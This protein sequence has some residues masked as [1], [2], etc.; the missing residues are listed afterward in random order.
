MSA[1]V[2]SIEYCTTRQERTMSIR[3]RSM[4]APSAV[5]PSFISAHP[6]RRWQDTHAFAGTRAEAVTGAVARAERGP[7]A[8][9]ARGGGACELGGKRVCFAPREINRTRTCEEG[10]VLGDG[11]AATTRQRTGLQPMQYTPIGTMCVQP[12]RRIAMK[13]APLPRRGRAPRTSA[14]HVQRAP[15]NAV[16]E[17]RPNTRPLMSECRVLSGTAGYCRV[18]PMARTYRCRYGEGVPA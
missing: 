9:G 18:R 14:P 6:P 2:V 16:H 1:G 3:A 15:E 13:P 10:R 7:R 11:P 5:R 4:C 8:A 17:P 12:S